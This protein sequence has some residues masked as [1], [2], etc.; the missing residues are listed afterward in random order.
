MSTPPPAPDRPRFPLEDAAG[1]LLALVFG[2]ASFVYP[3]GRDQGLYYYV[4]RE[5]ALRGTIP[6]RD[7]FDHKTPGIYVLH[8]LAVKVFGQVMWGIRVIDLVGVVAMAFVVAWLAAAPGKPITKGAVGRAALFVTLFHYGFLNF[9]D[10]A[11]SELHY[12]MLGCLALAAAQ[13]AVPERRALP[14]VSGLALGAALVMKPPVMWVG[15]GAVIVLGVRLRERRADVKA[16]AR[17]AA[18]FGLGAFLPLALTLAY[19]AKHGALAAMKDIVVGANGYYVSHEHAK[20]PVADG[21]DAVQGYLAHTS[22]IGALVVAAAA[23]AYAIAK[24]TG[25]DETRATY[26][27][28]LGVTAACFV[29]VAMQM[30]FYLLHFTPMIAP[31]ALLGVHASESASRGLEKLGFSAR[32]ARFAPWLVVLAGYF[33]SLQGRFWVEQQLAVSRYLSGKDDRQWYLHRYSFADT[34]FDYAD[35]EWVGLWLKEH[36]REDEPVLVRGFQPE[37]YASAQRRYPGRFFWTLFLTHPAR[38][39][40]REEYLAEDEKALAEAKPKYLVARRDYPDVDASNV[41]YYQARGYRPI[42]ERGYFVIMER[43]AP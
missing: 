8:A 11:Q 23:V 9:W 31:L 1:L 17:A 21:V 19:F 26:G 24:R 7:V 22:P 28:A 3:F 32:A 6:Y 10:T 5:W 29:C 43:V 34:H 27:R 42:V 16:I 35:S 4:G 15:L 25:D 13:H 14:F 37:V 38:A 30:K 18:S 41:A 12:T 40:R 33:S 39:Y 20:N 36:T 2:L